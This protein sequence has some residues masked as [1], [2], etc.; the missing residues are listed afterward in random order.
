VKFLEG[1]VSRVVRNLSISRILCITSDMRA[2]YLVMA[3]LVIFF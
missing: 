2:R 3:S 1:A